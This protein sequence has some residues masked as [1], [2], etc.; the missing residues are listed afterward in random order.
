[1]A[2]AKK[3]P[4]LDDVDVEAERQANQVVRN[5]PLT[6]EERL[7]AQNLFDTQPERRAAYFKQLGLEINPDND[8][9]YRPM[10]SQGGFAEIDPGVSAYFKKGGLKEVAKDLGDVG[11]DTAVQGLLAGGGAVAGNAVVPV[12]G[13][14]LGGF[15]GN[16]AAEGYKEAAGD[17]VLDESIP[18]DMKLQAMQSLI[19]G[20]APQI[21]KLGKKLTGEAVSGILAKSKEAIVNAA[22]RSGNGV[23]PEILEKAAKNP[24]MF[25]KEAVN[26]ATKRLEAEYKSLFG[27]A[28]DSALTT[29]STR[30]INPDSAFG[31]AVKPLNEAATEEIN[32]LAVNPQ[33]DWSVGEI[34]QPMKRE[35]AVLA[36][37]FRTKEEDAAL[38]Y[39]RDRMD[40]VYTKAAQRAGKRVEDYVEQVPIR[41]LV[42]AP[43][44]SDFIPSMYGGV[45]RAA[46]TGEQAAGDAVY[47]T[48]TR[49]RI[50]VP[51]REGWDNLKINFKEG[52]QILKSIQDDAFDREIPGSSYL[53]QVAGGRPDALRALADQKA[54]AVG[55]KLPEINAARSKILGIFETARQNI[56]PASITSAF[57]GDNTIQKLQTQEA[58]AQVDEVL[59]TQFT[60]AIQDNSMQ[61][62]IENLY[63]NP[64]G[65]GSGPLN[66]QIASGA[67]KGALAGATAGGGAGFLAGN[68]ALGAGLGAGVGAAGGA[69][70]AAAL[71]SPEAAL[72]AIAKTSA[73]AELAAQF[74][75]EPLSN[76]ALLGAIQAGGG[77]ARGLE[78]EAAQPVKKKNP[79]LE[80]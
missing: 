13:G 62:V 80:D 14:I 35:I 55:S 34:V 58:M 52:R 30:Q 24:E 29:R 18:N 1:M 49:S 19:V 70:K 68:P 27:V 47:R 32:K 38:G 59:G 17:L 74:A 20:A 33:A 5:T 36:D 28:P 75:T 69:L 78:G 12:I 45:S 8:N 77:V 22:A 37:K 63:R 16:F 67:A 3:N 26:G 73:G 25:S 54:A 51:D 79:F 43:I 46:S 21:M 23:T 50:R 66:A 44:E 40:E 65:F 64:K 41:E 4:F 48:A 42:S 39:L 53:K 76:A 11:F 60:K 6:T 31:R 10:G 2:D 15:A 71:S 56:K 57:V 72:N 61:R 7:I 9:E